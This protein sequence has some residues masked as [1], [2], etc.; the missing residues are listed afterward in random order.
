MKK[1]LLQ[2]L[3]AAVLSIA[4]GAALGYYADTKIFAGDYNGKLYK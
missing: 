1:F 4:I 2:L 3:I